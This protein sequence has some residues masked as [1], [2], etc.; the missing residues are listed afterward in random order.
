RPDMRS[1]SRREVLGAA[2][3]LA[4]VG[5]VAGL[6]GCDIGGS[7]KPDART[8][9]LAESSLVAFRGA[10]QAGITTP[11]Q[12]RLLYGTFDLLDDDR[13]ALRRLLRDWTTASADLTA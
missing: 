5:A 11:A 1:H 6:A 4:A 7:S 8:A 9:A 13:D 3:K 12:E 10:H 2:G